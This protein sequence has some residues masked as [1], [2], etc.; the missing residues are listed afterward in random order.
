MRGIVILVACAVTSSA[1]AGYYSNQYS[2]GNVPWPG[3][4]VPYE[5]DPALTAAQQQAYLAG[6]R[7]WELAANVQ[8]V[9]RTTETDYILF[10][11]APGGP[12]LVSGSQPQIIEINLLTR[13]QILHEM[14]HSFG[15]L[16]EHQRPDRG[17]F[18]DVCSANIVPSFVPFFAI[19]PAGVSVG[20]YDLHSVMHYG[21]DVGSVNPG[22]LDTIK[23][24][25]G[26]EPDQKRIGTALLSPDDR[27]AMTVLYGPP[28]TPLSSVVTTTADGGPGSLRA[29]I[30]FAE[31]N[32]GTTI[33]FDIPPADPGFANGVFTIQSLGELPPLFVDGM[34]I[35]ATTQPGYVGKP[36]I[37]LDGSLIVPEAGDVPG[38]LIY[39]S[40]CTVRGL[41]IH[42]FPWV[43]IAVLH[44][45]ATD[46]AIEACWLGLDHTG[47]AP[48]P[49]GFQGIQVSEGASD[50]RIG[51]NS[52]T[53]R[54]VLSGSVQYGILFSGA[55]T[56][57]NIVSGNYIGTNCDGTA[58]V[59]NALGG[60]LVFE[61]ANHNTIGGTEPGERNTISG[62]QT[63]GV[64]LDGAGVTNNTVAGNY[65]GLNAAGTA[66]LPNTAAGVHIVRG[67]SDNVISRNVLSGNG[68]DGCRIADVGTT[69]NRLVGNFAGTDASGLSAIPNGFVGV[70]IF[71]GAVGNIV[72]GS[73]PGEG[74]LLSGNA[75]MFSGYGIVFGEAGTDGNTAIGNICGLG[76]TGMPLPNKTAG[77][78]IWGGS[79]NNT[80][81]GAAPGEGN[82]L[83]GNDAYGIAL[84]DG[85]PTSGNTFSANSVFG[86]AFTGILVNAENNGQAAPSLNTAVL[87]GAGT[88]ITG[89]LTSTANTDFRIE[90]FASSGTPGFG[91]GATYLG[92]LPSITTNDTG[93]GMGTAAINVALA[94]MVP[95]G[96]VITAT[97]TNIA[98]GETSALS[99]SIVV[100]ATDM[101]G[102]GM[103]DAYEMANALDKTVNDAALDKDGDDRTNLEEFLSGTD[104]QSPTDRLELKS[105]AFSG[106]DAVVT[107]AT[108][109]GKS[110][111]VERTTSLAL[112]EW[113][114]L[115]TSLIA[116]GT[117]TTI[118][119]HGGALRP[120]V[121]YRAL[122]FP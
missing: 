56:T 95:I 74:N 50:N 89:S 65:L 17:P 3:G 62:N 5:F 105:L 10:K 61:Q 88:T 39:G 34:V 101:D 107:F 35:D 66:A 4:I 76:L 28:S 27:A 78:A 46:N 49:N 83:A 58:A 43:G 69:G 77:I 2:F 106:D 97:A 15:L 121:F 91:E 18:I 26:F 14:G 47:G 119:D 113:H 60:I 57:G 52:S 64:W 111:R 6:L 117:E 99:F 114:V 72:G 109:P 48:D 100:T 112:N 86:N 92:A 11:Y 70:G 90:F 45:G 75:G 102:D 12:N 103:P 16:H 110:Y 71:G 21:R 82:I 38:L 29:A 7:D 67:A 30:Y 51:G 93:G 73:A 20:G 108:V 33:T 80:V 9:P 24:K 68:S 53:E 96:N 55:T 120:R 36:L 81:G 1:T 118:N 8:F 85:A 23:V 13:A 25:P 22:V 19:D 40:D 116:T 115:V 31:A 94:A 37:V 44:E 87:S 42:S 63:C 54:N 84:F 32:P 79:Q 98:T 41:S 59:P 104:P 122:L